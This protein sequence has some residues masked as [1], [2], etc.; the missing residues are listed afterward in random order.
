M[1]ILRTGGEYARE[2][3]RLYGVKAT[4]FA[5]TGVILLIL[6]ISQIWILSLIFFGSFSK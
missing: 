5:L 2:Q 6:P 4:V 1:R 3:V